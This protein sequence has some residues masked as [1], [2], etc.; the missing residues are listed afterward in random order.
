MRRAALG[1]LAAQ[2]LGG[3][4][5]IFGLE[6]TV[7]RVDAAP[8]APWAAF[9]LGFLQ[10]SFDPAAAV[11]AP[12]LVPFPDLA[13]VQ[14]AP[15]NGPLEA[16]DATSTPGHY[17][18]KPSISMAGPFRLVY[19]RTGDPVVHEVQDLV[20]NVKIIEPLFGPISRPPVTV[21]AG[22]L[23]KPTN[24]PS[25]TGPRV[26]T[27]GTWTEGTGTPVGAN[28]DYAYE[29]PGTVSLSGPLGLPASTDAGILVDYTT[30]ATCRRSRG[31][32]RFP[33]DTIM[34][35]GEAIGDDWVT[36]QAARNTLPDPNIEVPPAIN[37]FSNGSFPKYR[38]NLGYLPSPA[39]PA[40][41]RPGENSGFSTA[42][43]R[44]PVQIVLRACSDAV[45]STRNSAET[46]V[47]R[48]PLL[49]NRLAEAVHTEVTTSYKIGTVDIVNGI[50]IVTL[51]ESAASSVPI[52]SDIAVAKDV[53]LGSGGGNT[54][55]FEGTAE[56]L[57][58]PGATGARTLTWTWGGV[59]ATEIP[60][61][62]FWEV[63]LLELGEFVTMPRKIY[64]VTNATTNAGTTTTSARID[65]A[66]IIPGKKYVFQISAFS[67]RPDAKTGD[68][69]RVLGNQQMS[70]VHTH[71]FIA[72]Q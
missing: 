57:P 49:S 18:V 11:P 15:A 55:L 10:L 64:T 36:N 71:S 27:V 50:S 63:S 21:N 59:S 38:E 56:L 51:N 1:L 6:E 33:L 31:S 41:S 58:V 43:L 67:G 7:L 25:Y 54:P 3:C 60:R 4:N 53:K 24:S 65:A 72:A 26:F 30:S 12:A 35:H 48:P 45:N 5:Q 22:F 52:S 29:A 13:S 32:S 42:V 20:D 46:Q 28:V 8:D 70:V 37:P 47:H 23:I 62:D 40:F 17:R 69:A 61:A 9:D 66:D 39:M 16:P 44:H 19:Q 68:F 2:A 34:A 14:I